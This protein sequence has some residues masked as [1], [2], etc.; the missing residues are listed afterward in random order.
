MNRKVL[1]A[2][3]DHNKGAGKPWFATIDRRT[4]RFRDWEADTWPSVSPGQDLFF[5]PLRFEGR[6]INEQATGFNLLFAD[7]DNYDAIH[8]RLH[9]IWPHALWKTSLDNAQGVW[10]LA[11]ALPAET[12]ADVNQ[13]LTYYLGAD[14][15]GWHAS[16]LLR[17]P[18]TPNWK[19]DPPQQGY[20][21]SFLPRAEPYDGGS[22]L[23]MLPPVENNR[24][25]AYMPP[26]PVLEDTQ[27]RQVLAAHWANIPLSIRAQLLEPAKHDRSLELLRVAN[28]L[29]RL[30][31]Q[32][33]AIFHIL[34]G[35]PWN[36]WR[37]DVHAPE[38]LWEIVRTAG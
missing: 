27:W 22:L 16:K 7:L 29:A 1:Q 26:P 14:K 38:K 13:R 36:K 20:V 6:R 12:W 30:G 32:S 33:E 19:Y 11:E 23:S 2:I 37:T 5:T 3:W 25:V 35:T 15:G 4:Q 24:G 28:K 31:F 17:V 18:E 21:M 9:T 10:F 8:G 34:W